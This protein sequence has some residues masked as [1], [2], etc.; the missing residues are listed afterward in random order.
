MYCEESVCGEINCVYLPE[1]G[2]NYQTLGKTDMK[3]RFL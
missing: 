3:I 2:I 1:G